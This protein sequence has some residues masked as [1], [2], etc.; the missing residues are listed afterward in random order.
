MRDFFKLYKTIVSV[1]ATTKVAKIAYV[2]ILAIC[3]PYL[4]L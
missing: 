2:K 4:S 3:S 1:L